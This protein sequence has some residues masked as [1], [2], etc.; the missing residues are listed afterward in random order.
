ME[1]PLISQEVLTFQQIGVDPQFASISNTALSQDKYLCIHEVSDAGSYIVIVDLQNN[2]AVSKNAMKPD[3]AVMHPSRNII[4]LTRGSIIQV[5]DLDQKRRLNSF[6]LGDEGLVVNYWKWIDEQTL[7]FVAG[8]SVFHWS[9]AD[10]SIPIPVF[11][12]RP[13]LASGSIMNYSVSH[14]QQW[15][16]VSGLVREGN[17][18]V[19]K[20]QLFS[21][22]KNVSQVIDAYVAAFA[23]VGSLQLLVHAS[24]ANGAM[25][26][27]IFP[28]GSTDAV[29]QYGKK[30]ADLPMYPNPQDELPLH[31]IIS[32]HYSS[33]FLF[34]RLGY[35]YCVEIET[36]FVYFSARVSRLPP[37][38]AAL[39]RDGNVIALYP[40]GKMYKFDLNQANIVDFIAT[41]C[42]NPQVAIKVATAAGL[43]ISDD[44]IN[45]QFDKLLQMGYYAEAAHFAIKSPGDALRNQATIEKL[46]RIPNGIGGVL[47]LHQYFTV[48]LANTK[49][50]EV[51]SI[52]LC[53]IMLQQNKINFIEK[54]I[55]EDKLTL[56]E[57]LGDLCKQDPRIALA[58]Y[59]RANVSSKIVVSF[60]ELGMFDQLQAYCQ[61][62]AYQPNWIH[63]A[64]IFAHQNPE[65]IGPVLTY[66]ANNG[67]P[68]VDPKE[69]VQMLLQFQLIKDATSFLIRVLPQ[70]REEDSEL[71]T[72]LFE[73][74]LN[75]APKLA[76]DLFSRNCFS[77][78][79]R[80]RVAALCQKL[81]IGILN[82]NTKAPKSE[83]N[84]NEL[85][86]R[87]EDQSLE[88]S[89]L[90]KK[91][92]DSE[93]I[94]KELK[95]TRQE[96]N[97]TVYLDQIRF[98][99]QHLGRYEQIQQ[100]DILNA[101]T[102]RH[103]DD[104]F[105]S[106]RKR[107]RKAAIFFGDEDEE[108]QK[109]LKKIGEGATSVA[110]KVIDD[111]TSEVICKKVLKNVDD[112]NVFKK[113][114]NSMKE[115][116]T[117]LGIDH[118]CICQA[119]GFN[120]REKVQ[121][122]DEYDDND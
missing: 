70:D 94:I 92:S 45:Q 20:V 36:S 82:N 35:L 74:A 99:E 34:T 109:V 5:F 102:H 79:D 83:D 6:D 65:K 12:L 14:D 89:S 16:V 53:K 73:I 19:G 110:Y 33:A 57:E 118:P 23:N 32:P 120:L 18:Q 10:R 50:N 104:S 88:I 2:N 49:L 7:A 85:L 17:Q 75:N 93:R 116:E 47:P 40:D 39:A 106:E 56:T 67:N 68:L 24:K 8:G 96:K 98:L 21:R 38:H 78:Y 22:E 108:H 107:E 101:K 27:N 4:A 113:L 11:Q 48:I 58:I 91:L 86:K 37:I 105:V 71:Q 26:L 9:L 69:L 121:P 112:E 122:N 29:Q 62:Y 115:I 117:L 63:V 25:R 59:L 52:E 100:F 31:L 87:I 15:L 55:K 60:A 1:V 64:T 44:L 42:D 77:Y 103:P 54:W 81:G 41:K 30:Y 97:E 51:E 72:L 84:T 80:Q 114:Q 28:L 43:Q 3:A 13:Q 111:R 66:I 90:K 95:K 61:K 76:E 46:R 119:I